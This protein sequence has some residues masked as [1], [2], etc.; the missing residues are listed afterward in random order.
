[1]TSSLSRVPKQLLSSALEATLG[2]RWMLFVD[3]E[4]FAIEARGQS[5]TAFGASLPEGPYYQKDVFAWL[6]RLDA[7]EGWYP[8]HREARVAKNA[9][10]AHYYTSFTG[11]DE[12]IHE[13]RR[14]IWKLGFT[15]EVFQKPKG[16]ASKGV[17]LMLARD[18]LVHAYRGNYDAA[19]LVA[20][21]GDYVPLVEDI[22]RLG[23]RVV[24]AYFLGAKSLNKNLVIES[25]VFV[26]LTAPFRKQWRREFE[27]AG[28]VP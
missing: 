4:N 26:D 11:D 20:G 25:D 17:D 7:T 22:K 19:V 12:A 27:A 23:K 21:D 6:P 8:L 14:K 3:G 1:M 2:S 15:P 9:V 24:L 18:V 10:R 13:V 28:G 5:A 16:Q